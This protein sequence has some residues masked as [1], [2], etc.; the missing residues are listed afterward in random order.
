MI[1]RTLYFSNPCYLAK[2]HH[3]LIVDYDD[4]ETNS[5]QVPIEDIGIMVID[6]YQVTFSAALM[7]ALIDQNAAVIFTDQKHMPSGLLL[8]FAEHHAF[9]EKMYC[10]IEASLP[11]K[12]SLWQ[13]TVAAK[14]RNQA[15]LLEIHGIDAENILRKN[16]LPI[17]NHSCNYTNVLAIKRKSI[18]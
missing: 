4:D 15:S 11:L 8:P 13:Q 6:H 7:Q 1:K 9:T 17:L 14:V 5:R 3:Q 18:I 2:K 12:K 10:Q 16:S